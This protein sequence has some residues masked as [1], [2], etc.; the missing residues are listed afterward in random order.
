VGVLVSFLLPWL[1]IFEA[2]VVRAQDDKA[3]P[4]ELKSIMKHGVS[5]QACRLTLAKVELAIV[6]VQGEYPW[7]WPLKL[8][9]DQK[10]RA[11]L[12]PWLDKV[13]D[14]LSSVVFE[15]DRIQCLRL[16]SNRRRKL[17][18]AGSNFSPKSL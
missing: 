5:C 6:L 2:E 18:E 8:P 13:A 12:L 1:A 15:A 16:R 14:C 10:H 11:D 4:A 17:A 3:T 7:R 9:R